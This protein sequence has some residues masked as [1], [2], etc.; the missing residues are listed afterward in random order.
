MKIRAMVRGALNFI[1]I[2]RYES[3]MSLSS[4]SKIHLKRYFNSIM[5]V[6]FMLIKMNL[7][8]PS[9]FKML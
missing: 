3:Q 6:L 8:L 4:V 2:I 9:H 5:R 1:V 7:S